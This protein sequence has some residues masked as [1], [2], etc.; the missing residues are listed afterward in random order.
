MIKIRIFNFYN[1]TTY[2]THLGLLWQY[3]QR[4]P[5]VHI[6]A[7]CTLSKML[8]TRSVFKVSIFSDFG[9]FAYHAVSCSW[10]PSLNRKFTDELYILYIHGLDAILHNVLHNCMKPKSVSYEP[11]ESKAVTLTH[12]YGQSATVW[13]HIISAKNLYATN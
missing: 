11:S 13:H 7:D 5:E 3:S 1:F 6:Q 4:Q 8:R 12:P 9:I 2:L 10:V